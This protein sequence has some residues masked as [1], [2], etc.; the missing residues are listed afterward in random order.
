M[1]LKFVAGVVFSIP[2]VIGVI[3]L[4]NAIATR[5]GARPVGMWGSKAA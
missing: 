4:T 2:A 3:V 1:I 5:A